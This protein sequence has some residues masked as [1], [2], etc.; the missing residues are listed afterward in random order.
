MG[1]LVAV[2]IYLKLIGPILALISL[3]LFF[4]YNRPK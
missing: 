3:G 1:G 2:S 4:Y